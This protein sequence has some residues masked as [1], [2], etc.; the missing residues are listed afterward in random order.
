MN[1]M[2]TPKEKFMQKAIAAARSAYDKN[3]YAVGAVLVKSGKIIA[4][5]GN[6]VRIRHDST[7]H[8]EVLVLQQ[9]SKKLKRR[10]LGDCILYS[11]AEPCPM[12][13]SAAVWSKVKGIVYGSTMQDMKTYQQTHGNK[14]WSWRTINVPCSYIVSKGTPRPFL[15]KGFMRKECIKLFHS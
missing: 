3:D 15:V 10:Y 14:S 8:A 12:C 6:R 11:T 7:Q 9:A 1:L 2:Y 5:A 4:V 13:A